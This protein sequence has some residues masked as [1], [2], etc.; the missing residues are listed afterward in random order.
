MQLDAVAGLQGEV[1]GSVHWS[2]DG[3]HL[4]TAAGQAVLHLSA[5]SG[6]QRFLH[7]HN[8]RVVC[9]KF[10]P[11][12]D[13]LATLQEG[14]AIISLRLWH[15]H[16]LECLCTLGLH[17][18]EALSF[19]FSSDST[20]IAVLSK[21]PSCNARVRVYDISSVKAAD[22]RT[23]EGTHAT[24][25]YSRALVTSDRTVRFSPHHMIQPMQ[26]LVLCGT[27]DPRM[28]RVKQNSLRPSVINLG[29]SR[30]VCG[31]H[32]RVLQQLTAVTFSSASAFDAID[33]RRMFFA[34]ASGDVLVVNC[35]SRKLERR[36]PLHMRCINALI[37]TSAFVASAADDGLVR[38]WPPA[39]DDD[40][41]L[42]AEHG[43]RPTSLSTSP[44]SLKIA[45][46]VEDGTLGVLD[47]PTHAF[48]RLISSHTGCINDLSFAHSTAASC[49][50]DGTVRLW[51]T[52]N[53]VLEQVLELG[54]AASAKDGPIAEH[55][56]PVRVALN[57]NAS[58]LA[59]GYVSGTVRVYT[60]PSMPA[61][62]NCSRTSRLPSALIATRKQHTSTPSSGGSACIRCV[63]F[64]HEHLLSVGSD[65]TACLYKPQTFEALRLLASDLPDQ[66][67]TT[68]R[69]PVTVSP[70]NK[71]LA[72]ATYD[73]SGAYVYDVQQQ[74]LCH[75][76]MRLP[77]ATVRITAMTFTQSSDCLVLATD[78]LQLHTYSIASS[79]RMQTL[80]LPASPAT[81]LCPLSNNI[82]AT[83][84]NG[85]VLVVQH[86]S[87]NDSSR[88]MEEY[89]G[90]SRT[91]T[92]SAQFGKQC[93]TGDELGSLLLWSLPEE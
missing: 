26:Q 29:T 43:A 37:A 65:G 49:S 31:L 56:E 86:D 28:L 62:N 93:I 41:L 69:E 57:H 44:D 25:L 6:E 42:E 32:K 35:A 38:V 13:V 46:A 15:T 79:A 30:Y 39:L 68:C 91:V 52:A 16:T 74:K 89:V 18:R 45:S 40:F 78:A 33:Q 3:S 8:R 71:L 50:R 75:E 77:Q 51:N 19:D 85:S 5:H 83:Q 10:A 20:L 81:S 34:C 22:E 27:G 2:P 14:P 21:T 11:S 67:N 24:L 12:G 61:S 23:K 76:Q 70:D 4:A 82:L 92:A 72:I 84:T 90:H 17:D 63:A 55:D 66:T 88:K 48:S 87:N 59:I 9:V 58:T 53:C 73:L 54:G 80:S 1:P 64:V 60:A 7:G 47:V 36:V